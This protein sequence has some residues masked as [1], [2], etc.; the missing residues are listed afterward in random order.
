MVRIKL[1]TDSPQHKN[2]RPKE[3][4]VWKSKQLGNRKKKS[5]TEKEKEK[6]KGKK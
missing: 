3:T 4:A 6:E 1:E 2:T 5:K